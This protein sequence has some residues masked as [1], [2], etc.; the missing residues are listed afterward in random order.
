MCLGATIIAAVHARK[1]AHVAVRVVVE[2]V[3]S[4]ARDAERPYF[5]G[6]LPM[7]NQ[8]WLSYIGVNKVYPPSREDEFTAL[9]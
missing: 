8:R 7:E 6:F 3:V 9:G 4:P 2:G 5:V 1:P